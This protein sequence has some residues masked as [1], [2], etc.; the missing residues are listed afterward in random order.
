MGAAW[1]SGPSAPVSGW[2]FR[3][4]RFSHGCGGCGFRG[5]GCSSRVPRL[6]APRFPGLEEFTAEF[7]RAG[8]EEV[9]DL[10]CEEDGGRLFWRIFRG[11]GGRTLAAICLAERPELSFYYFT[12]TSRLQSGRVF[13]TWNYPFTYGLK[14]FPGLEVRRVEG[15]CSFPALVESHRKFLAWHGIAE[16]SAVE[17]EPSRLAEVLE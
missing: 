7:E 4:S 15:E 6:P 16:T 17:I 10:G 8:F 3:G 1:L 9:A 12:I 5:G 14:F 13:M 2:C 11:P